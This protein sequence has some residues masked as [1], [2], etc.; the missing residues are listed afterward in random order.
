MNC[1]KKCFGASQDKDLEPGLVAMPEYCKDPE[2]EC[3]ELDR[4]LEGVKCPI[5]ECGLEECFAVAMR[6]FVKRDREGLLE[7]I[8]V[9]FDAAYRSE[10]WGDNQGDP[11]Y[12]REAMGHNEGIRKAKQI[13][14]SFK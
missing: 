3:H 8:I 12:R 4:L 2:C 1:C 9:Q 7:E 11:D 5:P 10:D 13:V 14:E 6:N